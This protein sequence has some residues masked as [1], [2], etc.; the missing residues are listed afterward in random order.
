MTHIQLVM[1]GIQEAKDCL[2]SGMKA[3]EIIEAL[4]A[5]YTPITKPVIQSIVS[6]AVK[7]SKLS[8]VTLN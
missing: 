7:N 2:A 4:Q 6:N 5:D 3:A 8:K 1:A